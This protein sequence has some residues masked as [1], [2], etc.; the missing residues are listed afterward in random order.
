MLSFNFLLDWLCVTDH[1]GWLKFAFRCFF[2]TF[3][4]EISIICFSL[5]TLQKCFQIKFS[6]LFLLIFK[7]PSPFI[8]CSCCS[9]QVDPNYPVQD[10][11]LFCPN[12]TIQTLSIPNISKCFCSSAVCSGM[13]SNFVIIWY[14]GTII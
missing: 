3:Y 1:L 11:S 10:I 8:S 7:S 13:K 5:S 2:Y 4:K 14:I 6:A 9:Y 12:Q